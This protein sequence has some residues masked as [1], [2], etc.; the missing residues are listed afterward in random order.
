MT[1]PTLASDTPP[2]PEARSFAPLALVALLL[3]GDYILFGG[4]GVNVPLFLLL[5]GGA[6]IV[7]GGKATSA[8]SKLIAGG[9]LALALLP[10]VETT[11]SL[12]GLFIAVFGLGIATALASGL[13]RGHLPDL[14]TTAVGFGLLAP[15]RL[16][17][18]LIGSMGATGMDGRWRRSLRLL[19]GWLLPLALGLVFLFLFA[20]A[21]PLIEQA[22]RA[23]SPGNAL[24]IDPAH[25]LLWI[26]IAAFSWPFL[27]PRVWRPQPKPK[28]EIKPEIYGLARTVPSSA[29]GHD[30]TRRSLIVFNAL[31]AVETALDLVYLWGGVGLPDG[32]TYAEYAHRGA[33][34]L[35]ATALL[36]ALFVL[37]TM[38]PGGAGE[39]DRLL[40]GLVFAFIGQNVLLVASSLLRLDLYVDVYGL[41]DLRLA[42]AVWMGLVGAGLVLILLR[43]FWRR[44]NG[45]L[46]AGNLVTLI[47]TLYAYAW[48]DTDALVAGFNL[49]RAK[50]QVAGRPLP[51][52]CHLRQQGPTI[53]P[54][55]DAY[56]AA[57]PDGSTLRAAAERARADLAERFAGR[58]TDWRDWTWRDARLAA[59][60]GATPPPS[61]TEVAANL[62]WCSS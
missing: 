47:A 43:I 24:T 56:L 62:D 52:I 60:L 13:W 61:R 59:Y 48:V 14:A 22:L 40:R 38:R 50:V 16:I 31:F 51:D 37:V 55:L 8:R 35:I 15:F 58:P 7:L 49:D 54:A 11:S 1:E 20:S 3:A 46:V 19:V 45:W 6:A 36:A 5:L 41:T 4:W 44:T 12:A 28:T 57:S 34:P 9:V 42:S 25:V 39:T 23:L 29:L 32:M 33:Y 27:A 10:L 17:S 18:D 30:F 26:M 2:P 53:I 21:N